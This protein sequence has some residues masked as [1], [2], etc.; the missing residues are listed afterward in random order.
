MSEPEYPRRFVARDA[1]LGDWPQIEPYFRQLAQ[2][3]L[4]TPEQLEDWLL[5]VSELAACLDQERVSREVEMT[6]ATDDQAREKRF[7]DFVRNIQPKLKPLMF[8]LQKKYVQAPARKTPSPKRYQVLD[9]SIANAVELFREENVP[10]ETEEDLLEQ[11][12]QKL[13]GAMTVSYRGTEYTLQQMSPFLLE[14]DRAVRQEAWELTA[15]RRLQDCQAIEELFD[16]MVRLRH[17]IARNAGFDNYLQF[18][19]RAKERFDY[20]EADC[21][22]FHQS[23]E[24]CVVPLLRELRHRRREQLGVDPLR[25][26]DLAVDVGGR[27]PLRPFQTSAR[28]IEGCTKVFRR[29]DP[30]LAAHLE[31]MN[32]GAWLDLESRK[33]K[34]PG[35]YQETYQEQRRPF[36]FMNAVGLHRDVETLLH[37]GGHAFHTFATRDEPLLAYRQPPIEFCEVASM[38]MELLCLDFLDEFYDAPNLARAEREQLEGIIAVLAW[39]ATIDAFQHWIYRNPDHTHRQRR[40]HWLEL[41][42]RFGGQEDYTGYERQLAYAWHRQP[43]PFIVPLYYIEYGIAQLGALQVWI[44]ARKDYRG[45]VQA[46][47]RALALGGSRPLPELFEAAAIRFDFSAGTLAP[48]VDALRAEL[49]KLPA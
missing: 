25:P 37:E 20:T 3:R 15:A 18:G 48:L 23:V 1:D 33:G 10:L 42:R 29:V 11:Q 41:H 6:R 14:N 39:I 46:Y 12:Y 8:A 45:A 44:N 36:I 49:D 5:R 4:D 30:E 21:R 2:A 47:R 22:A 38:G 43:H 13:C 35:G 31:T 19:F 40:E 28:L 16:R 32:A 24:R 7:L 17:Q 27:A 9:R 26:W 34:A